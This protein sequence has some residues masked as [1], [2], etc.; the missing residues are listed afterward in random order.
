[1]GG[2]DEASSLPEV[3]TTTENIKN[4]KDSSNNNK[5]IKVV[6]E[7]LGEIKLEKIEAVWE[8]VKECLAAEGV[9]AK[10]GKSACEINIIRSK[11]EDC[12]PEVVI[13][14]ALWTCKLLNKLTL[15]MPP[16]LFTTIPDSISRLTP[17]ITLIL[18]NNSLTSL[19]STIGT[20]TN[21]KNLDVSHNAL[22]SIPLQMGKLVNLESVDFSF[23]NLPSVAGL[24][25]CNNIVRYI[26]IFIYT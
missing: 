22:E 7:K 10:L 2:D 3:Q 23:N 14:P 13:D 20:L 18:K 6:E 17:L 8:E 26:F 9:D 11:G 4:E 25:G 24:N 5:N 21:L 15:Q 12:I 1:M 19:P 16:K